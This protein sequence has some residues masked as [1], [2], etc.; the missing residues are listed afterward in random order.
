MWTRALTSKPT[1]CLPDFVFFMFVFKSIR[2]LQPDKVLAFGYPA[3]LNIF[4]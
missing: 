3:D 1:I 4:F 2:S